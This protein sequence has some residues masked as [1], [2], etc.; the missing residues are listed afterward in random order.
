ML[1]HHIY[2][3]LE[4]RGEVR[5][6][7]RDWVLNEAL[8]PKKLQN[9]GTFRNVLT[10]KLDDVIIPIFAEIIGIVDYNYNLNLIGG[11][12]QNTSLSRLWL[13]IFRN[14]D[15]MKFHYEEMV[16]RQ[17]VPGVGGRMAEQDFR[18]QFPFSWLIKQAVDAQW[19][20][21]K[22]IAGTYSSS[23]TQYYILWLE[24]KN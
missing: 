3:L 12:S 17:Q 23:Q 2:N 6:D 22:S 20:Q 18:C 9:G 21:A 10:R 13:A 15:I 16:T 8:N 19:D 14:P 7:D 24:Y 11:L 5:A 1:I 4:Q